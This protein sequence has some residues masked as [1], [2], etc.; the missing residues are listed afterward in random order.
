M[1]ARAT[2]TDHQDPLDA[3]RQAGA[4]AWRPR[5]RRSSADQAEASVRLSPDWEAGAGRYDLTRRPYWREILDGFDDP[6]V[7]KITVRKSTQVGGTLTLIAALLAQAILAPCPVMVVLPTRDA[8][9]E[10]RDRVYF[11][12]LASPGLAHLVPPVSYWNTRHID[13]GKMRAYLAWSGS[14]QRLR[15]RACGRVYLSEIDAYSRIT[16]RGD[17]IKAAAERVKS[18]WRY[19]IYQESSPLGEDSAIAAE[20]DNSDRRQLWVPCPICG[21]WQPL[22]FFP[23]RS[24]DLA[25]RGGIAGYTDEK[26]NDLDPE[27]A[28]RA[29]YYVCLAGCQVDP[30]EKNGMVAGGRWV[31]QGQTV[32][33]SGRLRGKP[34]RGPRHAGYAIWSIHSD[35]ITLGDL[36]AA[37]L[38]HKRDGRRAEFI[39]DWLGLRPEP[40]RKM[41]TWH[42]LGTRLSNYHARGTVPARAWFLT[43]GADVQEAGV[44]YVARAWAGGVTSWLI[45]WGYLPRYDTGSND[46]IASDLK[47]LND[48]VVARLFPVDGK[49]PLGKDVLRPALALVDSNWRPRDVHEFVRRYDDR[50][51]A[52]RGDHKVKPSERWRR[53]VVERN[54]RTGEEYEGGGMEQWGIFV[55]VFKDDLAARFFLDPAEPGAWLFPAGMTG[56]GADYLRQI[57]NEKKTTEPDKNGR[58]TTRWR[59]K[60]S[61]IGNHYWDCE[62]YARAA[63]DMRLAEQRLTWDETTWRPPERPARKGPQPHAVDFDAR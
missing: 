40:A 49:T 52:C 25:G 10:F 62:V 55:N 50:V 37:W 38:E 34:E 27:A 28:R 2:T 61:T 48:A 46:G 14:P 20:Y 30:A 41:P 23:H 31:P 1:I 21:R 5:L 33:R 56:I 43:A 24:G 7:A 18:F 13:L 6:E 11:N 26:G 63:A 29:A 42:Q 16:G 4:D 17:P 35:T 60:S 19:T 36:A 59:L 12:A 8:A 3:L 22:R 32:D 47:Q 45:D 58:P 44:Y 39:Q 53:S 51:R 9:V 15:G 54:T 57:T